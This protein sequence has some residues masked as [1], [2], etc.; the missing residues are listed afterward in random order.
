MSLT[1]ILISDILELVYFIRCIFVLSLSL[2]FHTR[3][4]D[5]VKENDSECY[6]AIDRCL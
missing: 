6:G 2:K 1:E 5:Y 3:M 4:I